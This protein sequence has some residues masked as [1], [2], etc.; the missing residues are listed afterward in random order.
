MNA[1]TTETIHSAVMHRLLKSLLTRTDGRRKSLLK[2]PLD[3]HSLQRI[4]P[5]LQL[6]TELH[7]SLRTDVAWNAHSQPK[8]VPGYGTQ[9]LGRFNLSSR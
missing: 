5:S 3:L 7:K 6:P 2:G 4:R 1:E 8:R 9:A